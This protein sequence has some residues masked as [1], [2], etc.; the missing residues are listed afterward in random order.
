V[1]LVARGWLDCLVFSMGLNFAC[2]STAR[3]AAKLASIGGCVMSF[4]GGYFSLGKKV[5]SAISSIDMSSRRSRGFW[6]RDS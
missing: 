3:T 1:G 2:P 4:G 6:R 5:P